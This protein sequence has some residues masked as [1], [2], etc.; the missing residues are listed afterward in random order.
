MSNDLKIENMII[1]L[2][3]YNEEQ[4]RLINTCKEAIEQYKVMIENLEQKKNDKETFIL[5]Q[6]KGLLENV[7]MNNTKTQ[8]SYALPSGKII[9][10]KPEK[11]IKFNKDYDK[12]E[13]PE[14][15]IEVKEN[16]KWGEFKKALKINEDN[17]IVNTITGEIIENSCTIEV[18][19]EEMKIKL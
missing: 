9:I 5:N 7:K 3:E 2:K 18:K 10:K 15:F 1:E 11:V 17:K 4:D 8:L 13:I 14:E 12:N 19:S 16:I 6:V